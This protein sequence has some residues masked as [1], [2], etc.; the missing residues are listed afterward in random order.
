MRK[1]NRILALL[2]VLALCFSVP[3]LGEGAEALPMPGDHIGGFVVESVEPMDVLGATAVTFEHEK[4]GAKLLYLASDDANVS[5]GITFRTPA[6]DEKG[7]PHVFEHMT[8]CGSEKYPDA[9]LFFPFANQT[10][11]TYVN[12]STYHGMTT[13]PLSSL[14]EDQLMTMMDYYLSGVFQPL[15]YTE[16]RMV[17][18][19]AWR[20]ELNSPDDPLSITGTVY[21]EMQGALDLSRLHA[22]NV[23]NAMFKDG[24]TAHVSGGRPEA[25]RTLTYDELVAFHDAYYHPSN[26]LIV[27]YGNL[28]YQKFISYID[29][30]YIS[31]YDRQEVFVERGQVEPYTETLYAA[32]EAPVEQGAQTTDSTSISYAFTRNDATMEDALGLMLLCDVLNKDSSPVMRLMDE[33]LPNVEASCTLDVDCPS[34]VLSFDITAANEEDRDTFV[35]A[36]DEGLAQILRDGLSQD[37]LA[38]ALAGSKLS[39]MLTAEDSTLGVDAG[40]TISLFWM[41]FDSVDYYN[42]YERMVDTATAD[43]LTALL[44]KYLTDN[45]YRCVCVT[46]PAAGLAEKNAQDL[47]D[48]LARKKAA[49]SDTE[50]QE[51]AEQ[52]KSFMEWS[53]S[54]A[55]A[56][57]LKKLVNMTVEKLP[58]ILPAAQVKDDTADGVR[59][60][61]SEADVGGVAQTTLALD[62]S[63]IPVDKLM[64]ANMYLSLMGYLGTEQYGKE[65]LD[66]LITRYLGVLACSMS[67]QTSYDA[68]AS[69]VYSAS[70]TTLG[71][72]ENAE[73][74]KELLQEILLHTDLTQVKDIKNLLTQSL[75]GMRMGLDSPLSAQRNRCAATGSVA[76]AFNV[77]LDSIN[78][79]GYVKELIALADSDPA[80]L[81]AR[82]ESGRDALL[83]RNNAVVLCAGSKEA[84]EA[85]TKTAGELLAL[86]PETD[87]QPGDFSSLLLNMTSEAI[88]NNSTVHMNV[89]MTPSAEYTGKEIVLSALVGDKYLMP[90]LRNALGAYGAYASFNKFSDTLFT[91]RDPNF[92]KTY[93]IFAALPEY[94]RSAD[95]SQKD[96]DNYI[97]GSY[98]NLLTIQGKLSQ[99][100][101][102]AN[103]HWLGLTNETRLGWMKAAKATTVEDVR[104]LADRVENLVNN[105]VRSTSGVESFVT[106]HKDLFDS[107]IKLDEE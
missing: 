96:V 21:S 107:V 74:G 29:Q 46:K 4:N 9:N 83:H 3:A 56:E 92:E 28:D 39:L 18:R 43:G 34:P 51:L 7:K 63:L 26:A 66:T 54:P 103:Y 81:T 70:V 47:A 37:D 100:L 14:S 78:A 6:L 84:V 80:A 19:E 88:V 86:L 1:R 24:L 38:A 91:Y 11:N 95:I 67:A 25:I 31:K 53:A 72:T 48:E 93:E 49:M 79:Y 13:Y 52:S 65:E 17:S 44:K 23:M 22:A 106:E 42:A 41:A 12:A 35:Q 89:V 40:T 87:A 62:A 94:L 85:Y 16:P 97:I 55:D 105:G 2:F 10:Y 98:S 64:D 75:Y 102:A 45:A 69:N 60:I 27:L 5:F 73:K 104:A 71:L 82:L 30:E 57:I 33:R 8:I 20:Y 61:T 76:D 68:Q 101:T 90:Q 15:L 99:A 59:Y 58:E 50:I 77:Y 36:V 32:Y